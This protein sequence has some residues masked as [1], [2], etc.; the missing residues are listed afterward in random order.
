MEL[1]KILELIEK[2]DW[3]HELETNGYEK[4]YLAADN[5]D[6]TY[7]LLYKNDQILFEYDDGMNPCLVVIKITAGYGST[8]EEN[9]DYLIARLQ[10]LDKAFSET[11][12]PIEVFLALINIYGPAEI[13]AIIYY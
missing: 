10:D 4:Q 5:P 6:Y 8:M 12:F 2:E 7:T 3:K 9:R 11:G 1:I 13:Q